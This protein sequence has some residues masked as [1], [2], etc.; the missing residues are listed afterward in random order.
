[1]SRLGVALRAEFR[2][3]WRYRFLQA[4][5]FSGFMWLLILL[6]LPHDLRSMAEPYVI[7][8][9]LSI[10]GWFFI[11]GAVFF[12]KGDRTLNALVATPL[13][14]S[15]YL[16]SKLITLILLSTVLAVFVATVT[17]GTGY[18]LRLLLL[19]AVP[20]TLVMLLAGF[21]SSMPFTS[22]SNWFLPSTIPLAV[23]TFPAFHLAGILEQPWMY[24]IPTLGP[25]LFLGAAFGQTT[26]A[27]WQIAYGLI[28]PLIF[29]TLLW[30]PARYLFDRHVVA[31]TGGE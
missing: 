7:L 30:L 13:R 14:F 24:A 16:A 2:L 25:L 15:E 18:D 12:E 10:V 22:V 31:K 19:G 11:A 17:H 27:A 29:A 21:V 9:D 5:I 20:G 4:G 6:P 1:M 8:G 26:L 3:Q 28:Y 23:L